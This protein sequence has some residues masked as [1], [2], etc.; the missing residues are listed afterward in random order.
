V[1]YD[2]LLVVTITVTCYSWAPSSGDDLFSCGATSRPPQCKASCR[3]S[4]NVVFQFTFSL[5]K[6][7]SGNFLQQTAGNRKTV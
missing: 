1:N 7:P 2:N 4:E 3:L 5:S 6:Q